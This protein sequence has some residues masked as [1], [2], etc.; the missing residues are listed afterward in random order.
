MSY[1]PKP[2]SLAARVCA[3]F[4][5]HPD[6]ELSS[7]DIALKFDVES[8]SVAAL[9]A[10]AL[11]QHVLAREVRGGAAQYSAGAQINQVRG[12]A[13]TAAA[14]S[15]FGWD[16]SAAAPAPF[17]KA[18]AAKKARAKPVALP[19]PEALELEDDV[20]M[21]AALRSKGLDYTG[22]FARM[23]VGQSFKAEQRAGARLAARA[24]AWG[25]TNGGARFERR[26]LD[27]GST[28]VWRTA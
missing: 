18:A 14:S 27:D 26:L 21:P 20:P 8:A 6:E 4:V 10:T 15:V 7:K 3:Y 13:P 12:D 17:A 5:K 2:G 11:A 16:G 25:K 23:R 9:L 24:N 28:R 1:Q 19:P 22:L